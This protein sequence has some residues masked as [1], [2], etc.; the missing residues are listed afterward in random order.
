MVA[1]D[2]STFSLFAAYNVTSEDQIIPTISMAVEGIRNQTISAVLI[3]P[4]NFSECIENNA[5]IPM[6]FI[7][8]GTN[9]N[10]VQAFETGLI[11]PITEFKLQTHTFANYTVAD[12]ELVFDVPTWDSQILNYAVP[13]ILPLV[14]LGTT[15]NL[16][17]L[18]IVTE[19]PLPRLVLTPG[20]KSD[21]IISKLV[22]YSIVMFIQ[23]TEIFAM[24]NLFGL[25]CAGSLLDLYV[26]LFLVGF[27]GVCLGLM[28][29]GIANTPQQANQMFMTLFIMLT[30]FSGVFIQNAQIRPFMQVLS[31]FFPLYYAI[32]D[33][34]GIV[35][36]GLNLVNMNTVYILLLSGAYLLIGY[37]AF[38]RKK[39]EV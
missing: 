15:M 34:N 31:S 5:S 19:T 29:S 32:P 6:S 39:V 12:P 16:T 18:C 24:I 25:Y 8:D 37:I 35:L 22:A 13:I 11:E 4:V 26:G 36:R 27:S 1:N 20:G 14:I 38:T 7:G 28:V 3:L 9:L 10:V 23:T 30:L 33:I 17:S 2:T 21:F